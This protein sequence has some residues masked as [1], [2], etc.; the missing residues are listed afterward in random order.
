MASGWTVE[1][2]TEEP[3]SRGM[4]RMSQLFDVAIEDKG[5][6]LEAATYHARGTVIEIVARSKL[7]RK[8]RLSPGR[9]ALRTQG[10]SL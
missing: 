1:I 10:Y 6:A 7:P 9:I 4:R 5:K 2:T 3:S 8:A